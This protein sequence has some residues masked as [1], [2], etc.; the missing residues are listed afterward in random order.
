MSSGIIFSQFSFNAYFV[1]T[2]LLKLKIP[3][4]F[5]YHAEHSTVI[6]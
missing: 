2:R 1:K 6:I 3:S 5:R 4:A